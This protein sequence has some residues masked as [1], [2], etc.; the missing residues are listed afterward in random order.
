MILTDSDIERIRK[1]GVIGTHGN[2]VKGNGALLRYLSVGEACDK[3]TDFNFYK[4]KKSSIRRS[5]KSKSA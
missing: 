3:I 4:S 1:N 5:K 2:I